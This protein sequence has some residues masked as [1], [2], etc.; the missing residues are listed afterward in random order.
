MLPITPAER[1]SQLLPECRQAG[2]LALHLGQVPAGG[3]IDRRAVSRWSA[4]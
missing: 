3:G 4:L 2:N 1:R